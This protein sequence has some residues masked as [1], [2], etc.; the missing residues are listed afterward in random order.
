MHE[1]SARTEVQKI[2]SNTSDVE[3]VTPPEGTRLCVISVEG[4]SARVSLVGTAPDGTHG[5]V[6]AAGGPYTIFGNT[7]FKCASVDSSASTVNVT[8]FA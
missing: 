8:F 1:P 4:S 2:C 3:T 6:F 7:P 5:Q